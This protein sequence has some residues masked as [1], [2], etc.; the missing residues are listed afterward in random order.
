[1]QQMDQA[2]TDNSP[3]HAGEQAIQTRL[4][5]RETM[6]H[7]GRRMIRDQ[8]PDQHREFYAQLPFVAVGSV[9]SEGWP[10]ASIVPGKPGF[11]TS[12][13][14]EKLVIHANAVPGDPLADAIEPGAPLGLLGIELGTRRRNRVNVHVTESKPGETVL[15]VD[16]SFGNCPQYIQTRSLEFVRDPSASPAGP[17]A[18]ALTTLDD[19][20]R[21]MIRSADTFFVSSYVESE[22]GARNEGVDVSHRGGRPGFVKVDGDTLTVPD[23][24]GNKHFNT[25]GNF[26]S[27]PKA[28]LVFVDFETGDLLMLTG[29]VEI[30]WEDD[31]AVHA[32]KGAERAWRFSLVHG[33]RLKDALPL[34]WS[35]GEFSPNSLITGDWKEADA[36]IAAEA[37]REAWRDYR[38]T[39]VEDESEIIRSFYLEPADGDGL[40]PFEAGQFLTIRVSPEA[41]DKPVI[42]TY[43]LSSAPADGH[44]RISV[45][46]EPARSEDVPAGIVSN[47]L[48]DTVKVGDIIEAK[49]PKGDFVIDAAETRPA[50]LLAGGVGITPMISMARHVAVEGQ[51]TRH[52]RPLTIFHAAQTTGQRAFFKRFK[53]LEQ[54][55][56]GRIRY[57]S[58][59][60]RP[61]EGEQ[62]GVDFNGRGHIS[63]D[64]LRQVLSLDDYDFYLCGPAPFMQANYDNL[65]ELGVRDARIFAEAFGP[66]SLKRHPDEGGGVAF[67]PE[68]E[69]DQAVIGFA[70]SGFE[71]SWTAGDS[72]ILETAEDHG[73]NP[74]Y[75]CR[76][77][78]CGTCAV[79]L[80]AGKVAY[81]TEPK[82]ARADDEVLIC[83]A[84]PAK[85]SDSIEIEL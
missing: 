30:L 67:E 75:G 84:V 41:C 54:A 57:Y 69:A 39:R 62:P 15:A 82:A 31:P 63:T 51:R 42:R 26:Y 4:G 77:G 13:D 58:F 19:E 25:L 3:F 20:A 64:A 59:I 33:I 6:D 9:D 68:E 78:T 11:I 21:E 2:T 10:W 32:F 73:L 35:F 55:T 27:N 83:C 18:V 45:K 56:E 61:A 40:L 52:L 71:Q 14:P 17:A 50:V 24:S 37:K 7:F 46:R 79:K 36:V 81:R 47:H 65:R 28:G 76:S 44:Y 80:K 48:H 16:Q 8:M 34:R 23:F 38:V 1:M 74:E 49:A 22:Q 29:T 53:W 72:T 85:G 66:A 70:K 12:P 60:D 5:L 43:T